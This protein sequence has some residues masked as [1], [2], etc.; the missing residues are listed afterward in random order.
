MSAQPERSTSRRFAFCAGRARHHH[1]SHSGDFGVTTGMWDHGL[2]GAARRAFAKVW[3]C[4]MT[5]PL[6]EG[7]AADVRSGPGTDLGTLS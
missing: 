7:N 6:L 1:L 4:Q 2:F 5:A 3:Q